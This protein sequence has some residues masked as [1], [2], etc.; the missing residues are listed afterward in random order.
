METTRTL[1][2]LALNEEAVIIKTP[3][4]SDLS[5]RLLDL[6]FITGTKVRCVLTGPGAES[7]A[8]R[9]RGTTI[10][11]RKEDA[12]QIVIHDHRPRG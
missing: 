7:A 3:E 5:R 10:A 4:N 2:S 8:Y 6:G 1:N 11:L 9:I 12:S